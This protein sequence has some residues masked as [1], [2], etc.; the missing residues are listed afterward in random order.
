MLA[1]YQTSWTA[2][3]TRRWGNENSSTATYC[4]SGAPF[5]KNK[6]VVF[7]S[8]NFLWILVVQRVLEWSRIHFKYVVVHVGWAFKVVGKHIM[9]QNH[10]KITPK[11]SQEIGQ[12]WDT[13]LDSRLWLTRWMPDMLSCQRAN[14]TTRQHDNTTKTCSMLHT[15]SLPCPS[16]TF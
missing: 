14:T 10:C 3:A 1:L 8:G 13:A 15:T 12:N 7:F 6:K 4:V 5:F 2:V 11:K 9:H 16:F